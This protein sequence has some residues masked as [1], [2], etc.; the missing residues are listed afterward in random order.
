MTNA[1][2][3]RRIGPLLSVGAAATLLVAASGSSQAL[4]PARSLVNAGLYTSAPRPFEARLLSAHNRE[5]ALLGAAPLR[6]DP[7]LA[8][9]AASYGPALS[10]MGPYASTE[11]TTPVVASMPMAASAMP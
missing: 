7:T 4:S 8:I 1:W 6:W 2:M 10:A 3:Q 9:A 5:R 11:T